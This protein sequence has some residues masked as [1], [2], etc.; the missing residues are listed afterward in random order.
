[1]EGVSEHVTECK[2]NASCVPLSIHVDLLKCSLGSLS[3]CLIGP[4]REAVVY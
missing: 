1:M 4:E 3:A 2:I